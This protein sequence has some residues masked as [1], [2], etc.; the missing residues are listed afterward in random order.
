MSLTPPL[1]TSEEGSFARSTIVERK[2]AIIRQVLADNDYPE[3][4][5]AALED[6][7]GEIAGR[8]LQP[9]REAAPDVDEWN[10]ELERYQGH[11]WLE[12]PWYFAEAFFYRRLLEAVRY[13]QRGPWQ[14]HNP[15]AA[16][17]LRQMETEI[18]RLS[19]EWDDLYRLPTES[20][21]EA[22]VYSSLWGNR[23]D[24]SN[25]TVKEQV[26]AGLSA[27]LESRNVLIDHTSIL[28]GLLSTSVERVDF[29]SDNV[30]SDVLFDLALADFLLGEGW[31]TKI[32]FHLKG[33]PFFVSDA[34][35]EDVHTM[36]VLLS[37]GKTPAARGLASRLKAALSD[38]RLELREHPFWTSWKMFRQMSDELRNELDQADLVVLKGDVNYR[39]LLDDRHWPPTTRMEDVAGYFPAPLVAL[40]TLKGEIMVGLKP[41]QAEA[42]TAADPTWMINGKRGV[43]HFMKIAEKEH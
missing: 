2:P 3:D 29:I 17:K 28:Y 38:G 5:V 20:A 27:R 24:L 21:F 36:L 15:F 10:A 31:A 35:V 14:G 7:R 43:I 25:F 9:L 32:V 8:P 6:F 42:L 13:F 1:M 22:L 11:T 41:G 12:I 23:A 16:Q 26:R 33:Q 39:R 18:G 40:R 30:G 4:I 19:A 37:K 34:M